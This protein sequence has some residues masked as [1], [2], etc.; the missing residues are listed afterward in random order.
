MIK[1]REFIT[2][3]GGATAAWPLA[4]RAQ[5]PEWVQHIAVLMNTAANAGLEDIAEIRI[6]QVAGPF[7]FPWSIAFLPDGSFLVTDGLVAYNSSNLD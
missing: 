3:L 6:E 1:R 5:Q 4:S 7:E 2:L